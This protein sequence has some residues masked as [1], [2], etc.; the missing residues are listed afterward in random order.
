MTKTYK[1]LKAFERR[2][3]KTTDWADYFKL[4]GRIYK[5]YEYGDSYPSGQYVYFV[6]KRTR[7]AVEVKYIL[8]SVNYKNGERVEIGTYKLISVDFIKNMDLWRTDT[9]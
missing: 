9:L 6:N 4:G 2:V 1:D 7:D 3:S 5:I 8:P